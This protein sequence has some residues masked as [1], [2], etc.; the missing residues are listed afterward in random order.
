[1]LTLRKAFVPFSVLLYESVRAL[2]LKSLIRFAV[3]DAALLFQSSPFAS[4]SPD[5]E[6]VEEVE[7]GTSSLNPLQPL[8]AGPKGDRGPQCF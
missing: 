4:T 8:V 6:D 7:L 3:Q 2:P 1:M 5:V